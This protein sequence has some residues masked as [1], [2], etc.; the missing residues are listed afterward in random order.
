M[1]CHRHPRWHCYVLAQYKNSMQTAGEWEHLFTMAPESLAAIVLM[2]RTYGFHQDLSRSCLST[3]VT[4]DIFLLPKT[5]W[6]VKS[7]FSS[8][9]IEKHRWWCHLLDRMTTAPK[10]TGKNLQLL[11][12]EVLQNVMIPNYCSDVWPPAVS[13]CSRSLTCRHP[14]LPHLTRITYK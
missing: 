7:R 14:H 9:W 11:G 10:E 2:N 4:G 13:P 6:S 1:V 5:A 3:E 8:V 12:P